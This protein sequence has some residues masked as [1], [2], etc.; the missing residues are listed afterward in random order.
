MSSDDSAKKPDDVEGA[1]PPEPTK[2]SA[3]GV[4]A[5]DFRAHL[6][7]LSPL[8]PE[9]AA[10]LEAQKRA[11]ERAERLRALDVMGVPRSAQLRE[12]ALEASPRRTLA[13]EALVLSLQ[14][15]GQRRVGQVTVL[16]GPPGGGKSCAAARM[17]LHRRGL[18]LAAQEVALVPQ[19]GYSENSERW[20]RW[21]EASTL[22]LDDLGTER[23][24]PEDIADLLCRRFND[25]LWTIATTNLSKDAFGDRYLRCGA[26]MRLADRLRGQA[27][28]GCPAY[29]EADRKSLRG[30]G[31]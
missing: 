1:E 29:R 16:G 27:E 4:H 11:A 26:G 28:E 17:L 18:W 12:V 21:V 23:A 10:Q 5:L 14:W 30:V 24:D 6:A 22:V 2:K 7:R 19:N 9:Q 3:S 8:N 20:R 25:G 31:R 13:L 15:R